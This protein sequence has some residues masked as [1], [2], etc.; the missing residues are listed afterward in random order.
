MGVAQATTAS[1][2]AFTFGPDD[3]LRTRF[4]ISPLIELAAATYVVR[5]PR[6]FPEHRRWVEGAMP[7]LSGL[8]LD[9]LYTVNPL[10]R[11]AWPNFN[12][13][14]PLTPHPGIDDELARVAATDP[15]VV[16]ADV[17]RAYPEGV[18]AEAMPF[19][20]DPAHALAV[21]V[22]Q[23]RTFWVATL[24]PWWGR[25]AAFL[26]SEIAAR[27][28]RLVSIGGAA[29]FSDLDPS[30]TWNGRTLAVTPVKLEPRTVA[31]EGRGLLLIPSVLA[32]GAWPRVDA[33]WDPALT[34][35]PPG[36]GDLWQHD[37]RAAGALE[38]LIGRR[39]AALLRS[40]DR[41]ASTK[42]LAQRTGWSSGGV[43]TH[44]AVLRR[45]GLVTRRRDRR[46]VVYSRTAAGDALC[47]P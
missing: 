13:P 5:L 4:A 33:P 34:Y 18:P 42:V 35:Q 26:E 27:A 36:T 23:T 12:A 24:E 39:R 43:N 21:L 19:V 7:R 30:V 9:L 46:E 38:E 8:D 1:V 20:D 14:P 41:P 3:L 6:R 37:H 16:R 40:L 25:M 2:L 29:A 15:E 11:T 44:L 28:R 10:G 47:P 17:R 32:F 31:L 22:D 45:T